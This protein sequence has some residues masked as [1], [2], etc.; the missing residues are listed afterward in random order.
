M[1][2]LRIKKNLIIKDELY[3]DS[4]HRANLY[5]SFILMKCLPEPRRLQTL[6]VKP[7]CERVFSVAYAKP[8]IGRRVDDVTAY[9]RT[10]RRIALRM[11]LL[12]GRSR[13]GWSCPSIQIHCHVTNKRLSSVFY[14]HLCDYFYSNLCCEALSVRATSTGHAHL[15]TE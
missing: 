2:I 11:F 9:F 1:T 15:N 12:E 7:R 10:E 4:A 8:M 14:L 6:T 3:Y 5:C 13:V